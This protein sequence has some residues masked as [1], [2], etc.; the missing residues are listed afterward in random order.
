LALAR[1]QYAEAVR[2]CRRALAAA[3]PAGE[4][5][6][7]SAILGVAQVGCGERQQG[8]RNCELALSQARKSS[9]VSL[10]LDVEL[11]TAKARLESGDPAGALAM[12][13]EIEPLVSNLLLSHWYV[14]A[15]AA[16]ADRA[17]ARE[18]A[19]AATRRLD[20]IQRDWGQPAFQMYLT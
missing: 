3:P 18:Y 12:I 17:R 8:L 4:V 20:I 10:R 14:L 15:M 6:R 13:H 9:D 7:L 11:A 19:Q 1:G 5:W 16:R 2:D